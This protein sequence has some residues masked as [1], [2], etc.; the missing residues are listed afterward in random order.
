[1][2]NREGAKDAKKERSEIRKNHLQLRSPFSQ[3]FFA[4]LAPWR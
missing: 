4:F 1:M 3:F 2:D